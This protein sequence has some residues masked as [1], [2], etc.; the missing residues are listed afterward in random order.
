MVLL[1]HPLVKVILFQLVKHPGKAAPVVVHGMRVGRAQIL[2]A[3]CLRRPFLG[4]VG[5]VAEADVVVVK[6]Y[7]GGA[8]N[9]VVGDVISLCFP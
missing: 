4:I 2:A 1:D 6:L 5:R 3:A 8:K 7:G 9:S